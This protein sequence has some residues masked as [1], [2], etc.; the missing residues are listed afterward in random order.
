[1]ATP[2]GTTLDGAWTMCS[3]VTD[4]DRLVV[5]TKGLDIG[6]GQQAVHLVSLDRAAFE[7]AADW[8]GFGLDGTDSST[9]VVTSHPVPTSELVRFFPS[10]A[11][12]E[13]RARH[14]PLSVQTALVVGAAAAAAGIFSTFE[15]ELPEAV[16][17]TGVT[18][19]WEH[20]LASVDEA[21]EAWRPTGT[22]NPRACADV[23]LASTALVR[24][25][26]QAATDRFTGV[27]SSALD[28]DAPLCVALCDILVLSQH[29]L[30]SSRFEPWLQSIAA[31]GASDAQYV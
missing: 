3:G 24:A 21:Y 11:E 9:A 25:A 7:S 26:R 30:L 27:G 15:A 29:S 2:D 5:G 13:R 1:M 18:G 20:L 22:T 16:D 14:R 28:R 12:W 23:R 17:E 19:R 10:S 31:G 6:S 8:N 4:C